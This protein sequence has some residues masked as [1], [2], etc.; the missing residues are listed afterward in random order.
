MNTEPNFPPWLTFVDR[1]PDEGAL[2]RLMILNPVNDAVSV[3]VNRVIDAD[4]PR[5]APGASDLH[6]SAHPRP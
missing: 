4:P 6:T 3:M 1:A 2:L 5:Y